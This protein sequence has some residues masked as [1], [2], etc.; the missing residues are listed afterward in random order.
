MDEM[1]KSDNGNP[2]EIPLNVSGGSSEG[3]INGGE[4]EYL[5]TMSRS[6]DGDKKEG[7]ILPSDEKA[8]LTRPD[9]YLITESDKALFPTLLKE[10]ESSKHFVFDVETDGRHFIL[11]SLDGIGFYV[12]E[13]GHCYY[14]NLYK[15]SKGFVNF[16]IES[17][18]PVFESDKIGKVGFNIVFDMHILKNYGVDVNGPLLDAMIASYIANPNDRPFSLKSLV[19]R[20]LKI[21]MRHY[22]EIDREN[23]QDMAVYCMEDCR[24]TYLLYKNRK[25]EL[26]RTNLWR[27]LND[28]EMPFLRVLFDME[29]QGMKVDVDRL[30]ELRVK[31]EK[32]V[33][34]LK[35]E[36]CKIMFGTPYVI[37]RSKLL[38]GVSEESDNISISIMKTIKKV[39][40][41]VTVPFNI[42]SG[43]HLGELLYKIKKYPVFERTEKTKS[44]STDK[45]VFERLSEKGYEGMDVLMKYRSLSTL[46][47]KFIAPIL[48]EHMIA[49]RIYPSYLQHGTRTARLSSSSPNFQNLPVKTEDG[50][51]IRR[52]F[53]ADPGYKLIDADLSQIELRIMAHFSKDPNL[54][55]AYK[56]GADVHVMTGELVL[57]IRGREMT[58]TER[59]VA[60]GLNFG[61]SYGAGPRKFAAVANKELPSGSKLTEDMA[62]A[63]IKRFFDQYVGIKTLQL[64]YPREVRRTGYATTILGRRRYLPEI[65]LSKTDKASWAKA[66]AAER[67]AIS[68]L[69]Q[70][71]AGDIIKLAMI[72]ARSRGI[73]LKG[74]IHDQLLATAKVEDVE[75]RAAILKDCMENCGLKF[76]VPIVANVSVV[77]RWEG[78]SEEE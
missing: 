31:Y 30:S 20:H 44:P 58:K 77:D 72:K 45:A 26:V 21:D 62:K 27:L 56:T 1:K 35:D 38:S 73:I 3:T 40:Q 41:R 47:G 51:E 7:A 32:R 52:C 37:D 68:T 71:T 33:E 39:K 4:V 69:I 9:T 18:R 67:E 11:A 63:H 8:T 6:N 12:P 59:T 70:G 23:I 64:V 60:K 24:C 19:P 25:E 61:T 65:R 16:V 57:G 43:D 66:S 75:G 49:G 28:V 34:N 76:D 29:R 42:D 14:V 15:S 50:K 13:A 2:L 74:Q 36:F 17:L 48:D 22:E 54:L 78:V 55:K 5:D 10:L 53:V 46:T